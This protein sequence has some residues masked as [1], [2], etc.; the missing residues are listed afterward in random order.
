M[1]QGLR[2]YA[3]GPAG[4]LGRLSQGQILIILTSLRKIDGFRAFEDDFLFHRCS[5]FSRR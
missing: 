4:L 5:L 3:L 2:D 1:K